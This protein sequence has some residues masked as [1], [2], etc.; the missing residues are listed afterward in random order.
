[1]TLVYN[2][3]HCTIHFLDP[4]ALTIDYFNFRN[5]FGEAGYS[6]YMSHVAEWPATTIQIT[7]IVLSTHYHR[8]S[9]PWRLKNIPWSYGVPGELNLRPLKWYPSHICFDLVSHTKLSLLKIHIL[10]LVL[11]L[12]NC[13]PCL[14]YTSRCV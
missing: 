1:M 2:V 3:G 7:I 14:L 6:V 11:K 8:M 4:L 13:V 5:G 9:L 12:K 10:K